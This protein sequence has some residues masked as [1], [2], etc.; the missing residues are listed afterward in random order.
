MMLNTTQF[1][2]VWAGQVKTKDKEQ[3]YTRVI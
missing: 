2:E 1:H 3:G